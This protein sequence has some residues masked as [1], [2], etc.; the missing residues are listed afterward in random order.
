MVGCES[1]HTFVT[2]LNELHTVQKVR[3]Q[4]YFLQDYSLTHLE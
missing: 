1:Y 4:L 3:K 2:L